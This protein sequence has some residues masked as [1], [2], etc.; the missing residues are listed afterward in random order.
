[1]FLGG[2]AG[3]LVRINLTAKTIKEEKI[4]PEWQ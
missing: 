2:Y 3:K 4:N 1:M